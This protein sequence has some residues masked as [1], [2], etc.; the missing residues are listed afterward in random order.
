MRVYCDTSVL[1]A[2]SISDHPHNSQAIALLKEVRAAKLEGVISAHGT[3][4]FYAVLTRTPLSPPI[5][6][7]EAWRLLTQNI[8]PHF[9]VAVLT[10][11]QYASVLQ[12]AAEKGWMGG[13]VYDALH[14]EAATSNQCNRIY[15]FNLRHFLQLAPGLR[16]MICSP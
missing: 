11:Q 4:E 5:Y 1:V 15:T 2:A 16:E 12:Q 7:S 9:R 13:L 8:V 14:L 10:A 3:A 6:P